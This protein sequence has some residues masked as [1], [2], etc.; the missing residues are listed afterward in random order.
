MATLNIGMKVNRAITGAT[1]VNANA[2]AMVTYQCNSTSW[3]SGPSGPQTSGNNISTDISSEPTG[4]IQ[5]RY[6]GPAQAIPASFTVTRSVIISGP[7][8]SSYTVTWA[9][10]SGVELVNT[11]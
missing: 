10:V 4:Q 8:K 7:S 6:F 1:T 3:T 5:T 9:L 11:Q 2:Y